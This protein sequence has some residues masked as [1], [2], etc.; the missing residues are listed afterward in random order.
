MR[1]DARRAIAKRRS[2]GRPVEQRRAALRV[3]H[4]AASAR[5]TRDAFRFLAG[6]A[7]PAETNPA[8]TEAGAYVLQTSPRAGNSRHTAG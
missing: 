6:A 5:R 1:D 7:P 2:C 4:A 8:A 3:R